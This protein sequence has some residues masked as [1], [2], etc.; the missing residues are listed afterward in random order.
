MKKTF[1]IF[2]TILLVIFSYSSI[3]Y[4]AI[5]KNFFELKKLF[6]ENKINLVKK[7]IFPH[8]L[9]KQQEKIIA[10]NRETLIQKEALIK[11]LPIKDVNDEL[12]FREKLK[13]FSNQNYYNIKLD[14]N[15]ILEKFQTLDG[16]YYGINEY[17]PG[18]GYIE[19]H[20]DKLIIL[21]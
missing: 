3:S 20:L 2:F 4:L 12:I 14:E 13:Y 1:F 16:F 21:I 10:E 15:Y 5:N 7:I 19:F 6:K 11:N 18:S 8:K 17:Y 9:I